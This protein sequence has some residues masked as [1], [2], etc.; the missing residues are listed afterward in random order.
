MPE[1]VRRLTLPNIVCQ[2]YGI[3]Q[4]DVATYIITHLTHKI[5]F[6]NVLDTL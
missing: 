2:P 1:N 5:I 6:E 3:A 4:F